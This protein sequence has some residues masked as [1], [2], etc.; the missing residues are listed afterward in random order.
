MPEPGEVWETVI[1][2]VGDKIRPIQSQRKDGQKISVKDGFIYAGENGKQL[3]SIRWRNTG[4]A[5]RPLGRCS[6]DR[7]AARM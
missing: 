4:D 1:E 2:M 6:A 5:T 7:S 3:G